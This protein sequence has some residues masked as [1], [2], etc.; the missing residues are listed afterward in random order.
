MIEVGAMFICLNN[1]R[2]SSILKARTIDA[3]THSKMARALW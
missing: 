3:M 2:R 1:H